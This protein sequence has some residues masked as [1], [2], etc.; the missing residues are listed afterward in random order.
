M[1]RGLGRVLNM[2]NLFPLPVESERH[3][4][5]INVFTNQEVA[6]N[7]NFSIQSFYWGFIP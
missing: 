6:L 2:E 4:L 1:G 7:L 3:S 5:H